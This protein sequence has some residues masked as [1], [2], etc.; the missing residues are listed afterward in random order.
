M[1][2]YTL[3]INTSLL[4]EN[5]EKRY[6]N[7]PYFHE[8][9]SGLDLFV[10]EDI[11]FKPYETKFVD[12]GISCEMI[13]KNNK[14]VSYYLYARSSISKTPLILANSVG[15][16]DAGYRGNIIAA[17]RY[18]PFNNSNETYVLKKDTRIVQICSPTLEPF[19]VETI[20]ALSKTSRGCGGFGSTG[21]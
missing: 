16:I 5:E 9:D 1:T 12:M 13:N 6:R 2:H 21:A 10:R 8:G 19:K 15:I 11:K 7:N 3:Y 20:S 14:N 17:L 18:I 4:T